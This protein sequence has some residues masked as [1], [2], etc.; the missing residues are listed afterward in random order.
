MGSRA[1]SNIVDEITFQL[2]GLEITV[3]ARTVGVAPTVSASASARVLPRSGSELTPELQA[4]VLT[5]EQPTA[6]AG[7]PLAGLDH[8]VSQLRGTD[9]DWTPRA[10]LHRA[11]RAGVAT[12]L[13]LSGETC[14]GSSPGVP[15]QNTIYICLRCA[16]HPSGFWTSEYS[17]YLREIGGERGLKAPDSHSHGFASR[18]EGEAFLAGASRPWPVQL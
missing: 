15:Y 6:L 14:C 12:G 18:A 17:T 5:T 1:R 16:R 9:R 11:F 4:L 3:T 7:L 10:R 8:L 2:A 13:R